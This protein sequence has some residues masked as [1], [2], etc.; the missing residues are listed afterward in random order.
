MADTGDMGEWSIRQELSIESPIDT[1]WAYIGLPGQY[2]RW[3]APGAPECVITFDPLPGGAYREQYIDVDLHYDLD[4]TVI[5]F[6]PLQRMAFRRRTGG[7]LAPADLIDITLTPHGDR[8]MV[9]VDHSFEELP[10][11]R[12]QDAEVCYAAG[13]G[14]AL[15]VLRDLV[16]A[17]AA[18]D[19]AE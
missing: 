14:E 17:G 1:V 5:A 10:A 9:T 4:G 19:A 8:T 2:Q 7:S 6:V 12:R 16:T 18:A 13:W 3:C 15:R 11:N